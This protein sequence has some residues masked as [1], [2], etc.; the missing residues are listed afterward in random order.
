MRRPVTDEMV[1][2]PIAR[3]VAQDLSVVF[4]VSTGLVEWME[5]RE[6]FAHPAMADPV[7]TCSVRMTSEE[8]SI[9]P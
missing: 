5:F 2:A 9:L 1:N 6:R 4:M 8:R 7:W 3:G